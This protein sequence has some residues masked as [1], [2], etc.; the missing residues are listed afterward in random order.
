MPGDTL[1]RSDFGCVRLC[2]RTPLFV[3]S[4]R[5]RCLCRLYSIGHPFELS[6]CPCRT[7]VEIVVDVIIISIFD[8]H[9]LARTTCRETILHSVYNICMCLTEHCC[10]KCFL[11][12]LFF[13]LLLFFLSFF[14]VSATI[15]FVHVHIR[16]LFQNFILVFFPLHHFFIIITW[17]SLSLFHSAVYCPD[18]LFK[19]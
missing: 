5:V 3:C 15:I 4:M 19:H 17:I 11:A 16:Y 8:L 13:F 7:R 10:S 9:W 6:H 1:K 12:S 14:L 2:A 18:C